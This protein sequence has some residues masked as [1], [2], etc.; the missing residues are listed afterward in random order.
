MYLTINLYLCTEILKHINQKKMKKLA[1][2]LTVATVFAISCENK[3]TEEATTM[4][5]SAATEVTPVVDSAATP[6]V[7]S[8]ATA[9]TTAVETVKE[10]V[11]K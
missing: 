4:V 10:E 2:L 5:D 11:K 6:V 8:A 1:L 9:T 7:D 3:A